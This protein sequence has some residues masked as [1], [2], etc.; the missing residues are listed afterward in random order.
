MGLTERPCEVVA[1]VDN[2]V[3]QDGFEVYVHGFIVTDDGH[4]S[5]YS[6]E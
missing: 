5:L 2:A 1:K 6:T 3:V 4:R